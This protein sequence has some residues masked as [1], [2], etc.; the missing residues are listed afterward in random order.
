MPPT[1]KQGAVPAKGM[2]SSK[3]KGG[4]GPHR[5]TPPPPPPGPVPP[6]GPP[7]PPPGGEQLLL[8]KELKETVACPGVCE[9]E[10][11]AV[12]VDGITPELLAKLEQD[13]HCKLG[14]LDAL[15]NSPFYA[16]C[17]LNSHV[18]YK[19]EGDFALTLFWCND[20]K[21]KGWYVAEQPFLKVPSKP[22]QA[23]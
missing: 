22:H 10:P 11:I 5:P 7:P 8:L 6:S 4:T 13:G 9:Y 17:E 1:A 21:D 19:Q 18:A 12:F 23:W 3:G 20:A 15:L 16:V 14:H 2:P